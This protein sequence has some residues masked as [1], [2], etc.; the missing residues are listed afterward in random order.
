MDQRQCVNCRGRFTP[1]RNPH[2]RYCS[3]PICQRKR[4]C[5]Y[6]KQRLKQDS[7]YR[8]NQRASER[9]WHG[10]HPDYWRNYR[11]N[12]PHQA[13]RNRFNQKNRDQKRRHKRTTLSEI[14]L[15][16][17]MYAF[18]AKNVCLS[19]SYK[20]ILCEI[21]MLATIGRY[22]QGASDLLASSP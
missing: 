7:D 19:Y 8:A 10:K 15:L 6:Q 9:S 21:G 16:A 14:S 5:K 12:H 20:E 11:Q 2:Q 13:G 17:T 18:N 3:N 1:S 4:R 22:S